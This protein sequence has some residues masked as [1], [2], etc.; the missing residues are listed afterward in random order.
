MIA[1][2]E[3]LECPGCK[4]LIMKVDGCDW[5]QVRLYLAKVIASVSDA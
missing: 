2:K 4:V 5:M 1:R 3:A